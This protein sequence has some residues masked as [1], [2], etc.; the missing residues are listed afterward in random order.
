MNETLQKT[1][2]R[3]PFF[4]FVITVDKMDERSG[5]ANGGEFCGKRF[6]FV[7]VHAFL[8]FARRCCSGEGSEV[9]ERGCVCRK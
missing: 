6:A 9:E 2:I 5:R 4:L 3:R 7:I 1:E 8:S